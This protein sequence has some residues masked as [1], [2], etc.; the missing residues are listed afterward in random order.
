M[1]VALA[2]RSAVSDN[3][4]EEYYHYSSEQCCQMQER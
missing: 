1:V 3:R 2:V 4:S